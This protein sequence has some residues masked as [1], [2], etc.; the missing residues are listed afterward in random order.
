MNKKE[1]LSALKKLIREGKVT[2]REVMSLFE[3]SPQKQTQLLLIATYIGGL[4][5]ATGFT[6]M[7]YLN[8]ESLSSLLRIA[9]TLGLGLVFYAATFYFTGKKAFKAYN[10]AVY[11]LSTALITTGGFVLFDIGG[12]PWQDAWTAF[13]TFGLMFFFLLGNFKQLKRQDALLY[14]FVASFWSVHGLIQHV[15]IHFTIELAPY[16]ALGLVYF[17]LGILLHQ[18]KQVMTPVLLSAG[19]LLTMM[20]SFFEI[21]DRSTNH[22]STELIVPALASLGVF[23]GVQ[24]RRFSLI[25]VS[26]FV[27][28]IDM[29]YLIGRYFSE[30]IGWAF[31]LILIGFGV[32]GASYLAVA[33]KQRYFK[34]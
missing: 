22:W 10:N 30:S 27:L 13:V 24:M 34:K 17:M 26:L 23:L 6:I 7:A 14:A 21:V 19:A 16:I 33:V 4:L 5:A 29:A 3:G 18:G 20:G 9:I 28:T 31:S 8:W 12:H 25:C 1:T 15:D 2:K 11:F 32:I